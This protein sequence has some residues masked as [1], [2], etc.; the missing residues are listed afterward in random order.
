MPIKLDT[1]DNDMKPFQGHPIDPE[2]ADLRF[3]DKPTAEEHV[4]QQEELVEASESIGSYLMTEIEDLLRSV[5]LAAVSFTSG[6]IDGK[7]IED[8]CTEGAGFAS[9]IKNTLT[10]RV[11]PALKNLINMTTASYSKNVLGKH[12]LYRV[13][14][15]KEKGARLRLK[16]LQLA[17]N[18]LGGKVPG[19]TKALRDGDQVIIH[20]LF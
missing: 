16:R 11:A 2:L 3:V 20:L 13:I 7:K 17:E 15:S 8:P 10:K 1:S 9:D 19:L 12:E 14:V 5:D 4:K 6:E 18:N